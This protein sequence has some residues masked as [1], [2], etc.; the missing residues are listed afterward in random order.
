MFFNT[1]QFQFFEESYKITFIKLIMIKYSKMNEDLYIDIFNVHD[2]TLEL[3]NYKLPN[4]RCTYYQI[5]ENIRNKNHLLDYCEW[6]N[7]L[8]DYIYYISQDY[9]ETNIAESNSF[10]DISKFLNH[11]DE[12]SM[13]SILS[14][15]NEWINAD[16]DTSDIESS[17]INYPN[18][19]F[20]YAFYLF[21]GNKRY[22]LSQHSFFKTDKI[23]EALNIYV[24]E[25][26]RPGSSYLGAELG[27]PVEKA[28]EIAKEKGF[29]LK[30]VKIS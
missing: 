23:S 27:I 12:I 14:K 28:N 22:N 16:I 17:I 19:G 26:D 8:S 6:L 24:V 13:N 29:P 21:A 10:E 7:P 9:I 20:D 11:L 5:N 30:F 2:K 15:V 18:S 4:D 3:A 1:E 25:G